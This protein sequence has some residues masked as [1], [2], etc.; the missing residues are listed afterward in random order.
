MSR[1]ELR[2]VGQ[3]IAGA[4]R[5]LIAMHPQPDG[6]ALGSASALAGA[7]L[8]RGRAV[9][10]YCPE[11]V[12]ERFH[13]LA[14]LCTVVEDPGAVDIDVTVLLDCTDDR[15]L[16]RLQ[17]PRE[18]FGIV[19]ALDHHQTEHDFADHIY[20]DPTCAATGVVVYR[21]CEAMHWEVDCSMAEALYCAI[22]SDTGSFRYQNTTGETLRVAAALVDKGVDAWRVSSHLYESRPACQLRLLARVLQSLAFSPGGDVAFLRVEQQMLK[23]SGCD[24]EATEGFINFARGVEGVE[25]AMLERVR[26]DGVRVS[27][28]SRGRVDV[29]S[30][31]ARHG[32]GGH[33]NAAGFTARNDD[34]G[35]R[36]TLIEEVRR[37]A[38]EVDG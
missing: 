36:E 12:P 33:H 10:I 37:Q 29:A 15:S 16:S 25:V 8:K 32:G 14:G 13:F 30:F 27:L 3:I 4:E 9:E 22:L 38:G 35:L 2:T 31:A 18:R 17:W 5:V 1:S 11:G 23:E 26:E 7:L 6:D 24:E 19:V 28:R 21:L 34:P 20:R